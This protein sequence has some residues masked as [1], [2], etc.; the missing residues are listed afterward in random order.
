MLKWSGVEKSQ[1]D[2]WSPMRLLAT[3]LGAGKFAAENDLSSGREVLNDSD[4]L[5]LGAVIHRPQTARGE[6]SLPVLFAQPILLKSF[7]GNLAARPD[8]KQHISDRKTNDR[9]FF[10]CG[11]VGGRRN[12]ARPIIGWHAGEEQR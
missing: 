1:A 3:D 12:A 7:A 8:R 11:D 10:I 6:I 2:W 4:R 5:A 9:R